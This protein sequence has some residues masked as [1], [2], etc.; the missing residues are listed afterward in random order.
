[1]SYPARWAHNHESCEDKNLE[2]NSDGV[3]QGTVPGGTAGEADRSLV[4]IANM[5]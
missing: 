5:Q 4:K 2:R 3:L 1:M